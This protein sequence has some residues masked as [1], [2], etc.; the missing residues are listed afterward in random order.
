LTWLVNMAGEAV[1]GAK[2]TFE[3]LDHVP[4][5]QSP[6]DAIVLPSLSG[7]VEFKHVSFAYQGDA[8]PALEDIHLSV[9]PNQ[10]VALIGPTGSGKTSL[11]NLIPRFYDV[12]QGAVLVMSRWRGWSIWS[13]CGGESGSYSRP[14]SD[15][16]ENI[17]YSARDE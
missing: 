11:V 2:R 9:E 17:A 10:V 14:L 1:A 12:S 8:T 15:H 4:E 5:I 13:R 16:P 6:A 7:R 3:V